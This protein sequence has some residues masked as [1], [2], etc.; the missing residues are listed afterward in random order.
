MTIFDSIILGVVEGITEFLPI[1]STGHLILTEKLLGLKSAPSYDVIIQLGAILAAVWFFKSKILKLIKNSLETGIFKI[2]ILSIVIFSTFPAL[3]FGAFFGS[4]IKKY[5]F[6]E[7]TVSIM[8]IFVGIVIYLIE[9]RKT[10]Q[11]IF[12]LEDINIKKGIAIG[13]YQC[14]SMIPGTSR[15]AATILGGM[16]VNLN[17]ETA[18]EFS[19]FLAIPTMLAA[20]VHEIPEVLHTDLSFLHLGIGF[21]VS[22]IIALV[23]IKWFIKFIS[24]NNFKAFAIYRIILGLMILIIYYK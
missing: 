8:L 7:L 17:R 11:K 18:V 2:N 19:F 24:N 1:S 21:S 16:L 12:H 10:Y 5:L 4:R 9:S 23:V 6:N 22:F 3:F 13:F 15:S 14:I 20:T